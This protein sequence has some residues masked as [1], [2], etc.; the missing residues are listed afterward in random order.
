MLL[1]AGCLSPL[2]SRL[3]WRERSLA[4][5]GGLGRVLV[6]MNTVE[7]TFPRDGFQ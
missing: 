7:I 4:R 5:L 6:F 3:D 2:H 1:P